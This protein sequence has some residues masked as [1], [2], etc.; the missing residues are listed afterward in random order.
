MIGIKISEFTLTLDDLRKIT[1]DY[2]SEYLL[3]FYR[4]H[5]IRSYLWEAKECGDVNPFTIIKCNVAEGW[6]ERI[7]C[8]GPEELA[9]NPLQ[10]NIK[11]GPDGKAIRTKVD[12]K[13][14][15]DLLDAE[16][17]VIVTL[18]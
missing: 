2:N 11:C 8:K 6:V 12:C 15:V 16:G 4:G 10:S 5:L 13:V 1:W 7:E 9:R 17:N 18:S 3:G 14:V